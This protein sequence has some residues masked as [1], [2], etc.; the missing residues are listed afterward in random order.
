METKK[1][2]RFFLI[3][4]LD[5]GG[6][7]LQASVFSSS[8]PKWKVSEQPMHHLNTPWYL[9]GKPEWEPWTCA[10]YDFVEDNTL[11]EMFKW[12]KLVYN[13][14]TT[15]MSVPSIYKKDV[16]IQML[17]PGLEGDIVEQYT[18]FGAWPTDV[19]GGDL[20]MSSSGETMNVT[21]TFRYDYAQITG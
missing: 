17:G 9:A 15:K 8:R 13:P 19:E 11:K 6:A 20:D 1:K 21:A 2:N 5:V 12:Y 14:D 10:F 16:I 7:S 18:L 4:P 3:F